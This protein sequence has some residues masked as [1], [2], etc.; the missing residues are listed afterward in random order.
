MLSRNFDFIA[1]FFIAVIMLGFSQAAA[2][3]VPDVADTIRF[4]SAINANTQSCPIQVL[5]R[6]ANFLNQ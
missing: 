4:Q 1:V 2:I 5:S 3:K 6:I